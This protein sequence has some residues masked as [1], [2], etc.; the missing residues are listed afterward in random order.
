[1]IDVRHTAEGPVENGVA[2]AR[3][4]VKSG[5]LAMKGGREYDPKERAKTKTGGSSDKTALPP[6]APRETIAAQAGD[7]AIVAVHHLGV[8]AH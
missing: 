8:H 4:F 3:L 7:G 1:V 5:T 2:A 6:D